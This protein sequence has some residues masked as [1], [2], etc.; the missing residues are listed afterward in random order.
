ME[1]QP[2]GDWLSG[3]DVLQR[4]FSCMPCDLHLVRHYR[5]HHTVAPP[6]ISSPQQ[7]WA[8]SL[9]H[10]YIEAQNQGLIN[11]EYWKR[12]HWC[13][14]DC[15]FAS[16]NLKGLPQAYVKV[17]RTSRRKKKK[18]MT[19]NYANLCVVIRWTYGPTSYTTSKCVSGVRTKKRN[20]ANT[21]AASHRTSRTT[22]GLT[23]DGVTSGLTTSKSSFLAYT[24]VGTRRRIP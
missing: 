5:E 13:P 4:T 18:G 11:E 10:K 23:R 21:I 6:D 17:P 8:R 12:L 15:G 1:L 3:A 24:D 22:E 20:L 9:P 2:I 7:Q 14:Y 19:V 16:L